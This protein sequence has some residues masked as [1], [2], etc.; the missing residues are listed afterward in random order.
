MHLQPLEFLYH[1]TYLDEKCQKGTHDQTLVQP[2]WYK[3]V[4][5]II[6]LNIRLCEKKRCLVL[7]LEVRSFFIKYLV[8]LKPIKVAKIY[9][10]KNKSVKQS[11][12]L[13]FVFLPQEAI[14]VKQNSNLF[15][16]YRLD[17]FRPGTSNACDVTFLIDRHTADDKNIFKAIN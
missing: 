5:F 15:Y 13:I 17:N 4:R 11:V 14:L 6:F 10:Q 2:K 3:V 8:S 7:L 9:Q 12:G 1:Y 16:S